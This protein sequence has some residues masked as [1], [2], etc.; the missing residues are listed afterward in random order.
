[1]CYD[2]P[3]FESRIHCV[4]MKFIFYLCIPSLCRK[5]GTLTLHFTKFS[6]FFGTAPPAAVQPLTTSRWTNES[7]VMFEEEDDIFADMPE[8]FLDEPAV[9]PK[10]LVTG[11]IL[12]STL[13]G[14]TQSRINVTRTPSENTFAEYGYRR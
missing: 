13:S 3:H 1:M 8:G 6:I 11:R 7:N 4:A 10:E 14:S 12:P 2:G 9:R 5:I